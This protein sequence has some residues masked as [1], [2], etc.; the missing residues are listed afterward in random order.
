LYKPVVDAIQKAWEGHT[1]QGIP[2]IFEVIVVPDIRGTPAD[3]DTNRLADRIRIVEGA[4]RS[5]GHG[6]PYYKRHSGRWYT[7]TSAY[8][9]EAMHG[10]GLEDHYNDPLTPGY[11]KTLPYGAPIPPAWKG[12]IMHTCTPP[13]TQIAIDAFM[14]G[15]PSYHNGNFGVIDHQGPVSDWTWP[16]LKRQAGPAT[17]T[18]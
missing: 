2:I 3:P 5:V 14:E 11:D 1:Y 7:E 18:P 17:E 4:G 16:T 13:V 9:H 8:E 12:D 15:D 10:L 6:A